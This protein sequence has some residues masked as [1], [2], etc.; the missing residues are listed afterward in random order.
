MTR[1]DKISCLKIGVYVTLIINL[2][3]LIGCLL[4]L[5]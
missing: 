2:T 3:I 4:I 1:D 5:N